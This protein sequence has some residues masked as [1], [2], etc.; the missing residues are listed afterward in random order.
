MTGSWRLRKKN[1]MF[2]EAH[3]CRS[4]SDSPALELNGNVLNATIRLMKVFS[5]LHLKLI[6]IEKYKLAFKNTK[7][8]TD[9][10]GPSDPG[11]KLYSHKKS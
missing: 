3:L 7:F 4:L 9:N 6:Q 11:V 10:V 5:V 1:L 8:L 2:T